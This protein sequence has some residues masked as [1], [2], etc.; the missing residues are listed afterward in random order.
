MAAGEGSD[1]FKSYGDLSVHTLM[2]KDKPRTLAYKEFIEKNQFLFRDKVVLDV[3]AGSGILSLFSASAGASMVYAVEASNMADLCS[4]IIQCNKMEDKIKVIKGRIEEVELPV[5]KVDIIVSEWMGFYLLHESM[6]DSV[7]FARDKWLSDSGIMI[8]SHATLYLTPVNMS[9]YVTENFRFW[10]NVYGYDFSPLQTVSMTSTLQQPVIESIDPKQCMS[11]PEIVKE[12]DLLTTK[13]ED[14]KTVQNTFTFK[15]TKSG[16]VHAFAAWFDVYFGAPT[17]S[18]PPSSPGKDIPRVHLV[19]L[20]T[21]PM[22]EVTHWKQTVVF[23]PVSAAVDEEDSLSCKLELSQDA[24]NP[25]LYNISIETMEDQSESE[26]SD[27]EEEEDV[28]DHPIP[29]D[30]GAGKCRLIAA[31]MQKYDEEQTALELEA[32][33]MEACAATEAARNMDLVEN[34]GGQQVNGCLDE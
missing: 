23:I 30:C 20:S 16:L 9:K 27:S 7:I 13:V 2:L 5:E 14:L 25:R 31:L 28:S 32:E 6:L 8:P 34:G 11:D 26:E 21:S 33:E 4:Q 17:V 18:I 1:Y 10:E 19:T 3:G 15:M 12:F 22:V 29:C 24:T